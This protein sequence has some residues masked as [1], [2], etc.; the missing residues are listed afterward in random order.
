MRTYLTLPLIKYWVIFLWWLST[1]MVAC[2]RNHELPDVC[3][4]SWPPTSC[5]VH[6]DVNFTLFIQLCKELLSPAV[7]Y[8]QH[9]W[10]PGCVYSH[11]K[12]CYSRGDAS[13][14]DILL[15]PV[16]L[17]AYVCC[18]SNKVHIQTNIFQR[19]QPIYFRVKQLYLDGLVT[20]NKLVGWPMI[21]IFCRWIPSK[22]WAR[23]SSRKFPDFLSIKKMLCYFP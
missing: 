1:V 5:S 17:M 19:L 12:I 6:P 9:V 11:V 13:H 15:L 21:L 8:I 22:S 10:T 18:L 20:N 3:W 14:S 2:Y 23:K 4:A 16:R 7:G